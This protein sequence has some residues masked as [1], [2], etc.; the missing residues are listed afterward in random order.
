MHE[1][2]ELRPGMDI[3]YE[4]Y[5]TKRNHIF[6][7]LRLNDNPSNTAPVTAQVAEVNMVLCEQCSDE[8]INETEPTNVYG[9]NKWLGTQCRRNFYGSD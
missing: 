7:G 2:K 1:F 8:Y 4:C 5:N 6:G 3:C 9:D